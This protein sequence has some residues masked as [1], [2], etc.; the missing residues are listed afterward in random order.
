MASLKS[1]EARLARLEARVAAVPDPEEQEA[2]DERWFLHTDT[3]L[4]EGSFEDMPEKDRD[5]SMWESLSRYG[6]SYLGLIWEG[7]LPGREELLAAGV[8]FTRA[9]GCED[10]VGGRRYGAPAPDTPRKL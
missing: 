5:A 6:P 2:R 9:R 8:D 10:F 3:W 4:L 1:L 7:I